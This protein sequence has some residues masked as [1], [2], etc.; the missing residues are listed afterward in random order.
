METVAAA[1]S[2]QL[3]RPAEENPHSMAD[4]GS[5]LGRVKRD[6]WTVE[7]VALIGGSGRRMV[8]GSYADSMHDRRLRI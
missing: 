4:H 5:C 2:N 7:R 1:G 3:G 6:G 8:R